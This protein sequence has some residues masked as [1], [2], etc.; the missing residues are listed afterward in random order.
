MRVLF[1][2]T[3]AQ[4]IQQMKEYIV[5]SGFEFAVKEPSAPTIKPEK[6]PKP[7]SMV[8][9]NTDVTKFRN[10]QYCP[11]SFTKIGRRVQHEKYCIGNPNKI[12]HP[13][14]GKK[15]GPRDCEVTKKYVKG[16]FG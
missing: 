9:V 15:H 4:V 14:K 12:D 11:K 10:C 13:R 5:R 7:T 1:E 2:G 8:T 6:T 16:G 3:P